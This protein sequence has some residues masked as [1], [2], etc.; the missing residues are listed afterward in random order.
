MIKNS[1]YLLLLLFTMACAIQVKAQ[2]L[3]APGIAEINASSSPQVQVSHTGNS[4]VEYEGRPLKISVW[5]GHSPGFHVDYD[6]GAVTDEYKL[7][8]VGTSAG[9]TPQDPDVVIGPLSDG[10]F[11]IVYVWQGG[12]IFMESWKFDGVNCIPD[13]PPT[14]ISSPGEYC[15]NPNI[16]QSVEIGAIVWRQGDDIKGRTINMFTL[17]LGPEVEF[18]GCMNGEKSLPDVSVYSNGFNRIANVVFLRENNAGAQQLFYQR[19]NLNDFEV[20]TPAPCAFPNLRMLKSHA[21]SADGI[22]YRPRIA[23]T[24]YSTT[25]PHDYRDCHIVVTEYL[26]GL[27]TRVTGF[28]HRESVWGAENFHEETHSN[29]VDADLTQCGNFNPAVSYIGCQRILVGWTYRELFSGPCLATSGYQ[30]VGRL[31]N[32]S[33]QPVQ[34]NFS[35]I[36]QDLSE[37]HWCTSVSGRYISQFTYVATGFVTFTRSNTHKVRYKTIN[38]NSSVMKQAETAEPMAPLDNIFPNPFNNQLTIGVENTSDQLLTS[39]E[40]MDLNGRVLKT[41]AGNDLLK[42]YQE[43]QWN[44]DSQPAGIYLIRLTRN[45]DV[46][47]KKVTK[48]K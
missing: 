11:V 9:G 46:I 33:G 39:V 42:G 29:A 12:R 21:S 45:D 3:Q 23:S 22:F 2:P 48:M 32:L 31:L 47:L 6:N 28:N 1:N 30:I 40:I 27:T 36:S 15:D 25:T 44:A 17:G 41:W 8:S 16:D 10:K 37:K 24:P 7:Q 18:A 20:G 19:I 35:R 43:L 5:D 34:T 38:C 14:M 26:P 13:L 4:V